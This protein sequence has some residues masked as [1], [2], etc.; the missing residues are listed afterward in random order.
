ME[1]FHTL[2]VDRPFETM[3]NRTKNARMEA[4][5]GGLRI[6]RVNLVNILDAAKD[7]FTAMTGHPCAACI[8][9]IDPD[10]FDGDI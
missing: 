5:R 3:S 1:I 7:L 6:V 9:L 8:Q 2:F 4:I 10:D